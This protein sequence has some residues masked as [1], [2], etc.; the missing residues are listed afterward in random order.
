MSTAVPRVY[1]YCSSILAVY[2][3][4]YSVRNE[5]FVHI[6]QFFSSGRRSF[7]LLSAAGHAGARVCTRFKFG[8]RTRSVVRAL[9]VQSREIWRATTVSPSDEPSPIRLM[10]THDFLQKGR[11]LQYFW[12]CCIYIRSS[13]TTRVRP[14]LLTISLY[15]SHGARSILPA[16]VCL[17]ALEAHSF[18]ARLVCWAC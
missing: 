5:L 16:F 12:V 3:V 13:C 14:I 17:A 4:S 7:L 10:E 6:V 15:S 2:P 11:M 9:G 18:V 1:W 8:P